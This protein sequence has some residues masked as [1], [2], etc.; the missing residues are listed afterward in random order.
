MEYY[1]GRKIDFPGINK[2]SFH[3]LFVELEKIAE[4]ADKNVAAYFNELLA[5][6]RKHPV[7]EEGIED[8][9]TIEVHRELIDKL[10]RVIFPPALTLNEIK[11]ATPPFVFTPFYTSQRFRN[12]IDK[13]GKD[14]RMEPEGYSEDELYIL[15]C[16]VILMIHHNFA[17]NI[18]RPWLVGIPEKDTGDVRHYRSAFNADFMEVI[19]TASAPKLTEK[20]FVELMDNYTDVELWKKKIPPN[21]YIMRGIGIISFMDVN[22]DQ[23]IS[24]LQANMLEKSPDTF[25]KVRDNVR[26]MLGIR[27][28]Q[29]GFL[30]FENGEFVKPPKEGMR[31][32]MLDKADHVKPHGSICSM[33][34]HNLIDERK[35]FVVS[36]VEY[37]NSMVDNFL[38]NTLFDQD[39]KSY[40]ITP[41]MHDDE[42]MGFLELAS[43]RKHELNSGTIKILDNILPTLGAAS[44]RF[45]EEERNRIEAIIQSECTTIH[46]SVKW[47]FV[48]SAK[49]FLMEQ[50]AGGEPNFKDIVFR[51]VF[52]L[53]GQTDI[54][55][56]STI[57]NKAIQADLGAQLNGVKKIFEL[58]FEQEALPV[59]EETSF[60]LNAALEELESTLQAGSE[61]RILNLLNDDIYPT[62][63]HLKSLGGKVAKAV[64]NYEARLHPVLNLIYEERRNFDE[65]VEKLNQ[66]LANTIDQR[67]EEAQ[68]MFPHYF[69]RYKTDGVEYNIYAGASISK[70]QK[71]HP[72]FL[73]NLQL[74]QLIT[75]VDMER[76]Y[77]KILPELAS[78][79]EVASLIL[80]YNA[81]LSVH[82]RMDEKR[83]DVEG[84]YNARYEIIKKRVDKAHIKGTNERVTQP[85]KIAIIYSSQE[86]AQDYRNYIRFL[87]AKGYLQ[88]N[89]LE[90]VQLEDLQGITG[91]RALRATVAHGGEE[92]SVSMDE[93][94]AAIEDN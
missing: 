80:A 1:D 14:F 5:E 42:V 91:L 11:A 65:S 21:S 25:D 30:G 46:P 29:T 77:K 70:D 72:L 88:A 62:F 45:Q 27:D 60:R 7:L 92:N 87:E 41:V 23:S 36:D 44:F 10:M 6:A 32:I 55:S 63:R 19:P 28:L 59:Y 47:S 39:I 73:R 78:P 61:H 93:L 57:R 3:K 2:V 69:E 48:E 13:A 8:F 26:S 33:S 75:T 84:A 89:T 79:L 17:P 38:S 74:W 40:L 12:I 24:M 22:I 35:A 52:P 53:Y 94:I 71:F 90:D 43:P 67:Q 68:T 81:P 31:C 50:D 66:T 49:K 16:S 51:N 15:G 83:F 20:D 58:A 18:S 76:A 56:S 54:K 34:E 64:S 9:E 82:F 86:D 37:Y 4:N 85:G